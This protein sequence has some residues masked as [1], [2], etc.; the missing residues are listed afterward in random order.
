MIDNRFNKTLTIMLIVIGIAI[1]VALGFA[2]YDL[3]QKF[4]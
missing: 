4:I 1:V 3:I 2:G